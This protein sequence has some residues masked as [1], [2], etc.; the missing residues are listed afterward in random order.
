MPYMDDAPENN[1]FLLG[2]EKYDLLPDFWKFCE[3]QF[4]YADT[5]PSLEKLLITMFVPYADSFCSR[6]SKYFTKIQSFLFLI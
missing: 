5:K 2:F 3:Q 1:K 6:Y 4:G